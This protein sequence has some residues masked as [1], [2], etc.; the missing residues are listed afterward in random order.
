MVCALLLG[1]LITGAQGAEEARV[2]LGVEG[3][4]LLLPRGGEPERGPAGV[5][6]V[7]HLH[8]S[9]EAVA[10]A[11]DRA[12][13]NLPV[14]VFNRKGLSSVYTA[15]FLENMDLLA[16]L[17]E[18]SREVLKRERPGWGFPEEPGLLVSSFSAGF[19]GVRELLKT[20]E[21]RRRVVGLVLAD[22]L[23]CGYEGDDP[24]LGLDAEKMAGFRAYAREAAASRKRLVVSHSAQRPEGYASTTETAEDL[25]RTVGALGVEVRKELDEGWVQVVSVR[26]GGFEVLGF[27]G[28]GAEDHLK[29]LRRLDLLW[30]AF[31]GL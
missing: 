30:K 1:V 28:E 22:S 16:G 31:G 14:L 10:A 15:P 7:I 5:D 11:R 4:V 25:A 21:N 6:L 20:E 8:G 18:E 9:V 12:G 26:K 17:V 2:G 23:Y 29:H 27:E 19:G 24:A 3:A 13:W